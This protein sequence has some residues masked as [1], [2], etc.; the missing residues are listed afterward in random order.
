MC[1]RDRP[2]EN[3]ANKNFIQL[4]TRKFIKAPEKDAYLLNVSANGV[5]IEGDTYAGTFYG[6]QS[7][8]QL[9]P[10]AKSNFFKIPYVSIQDYPRFAYRGLMLDA[11]R[12]FFPV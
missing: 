3:E 12:H 7:L 9:L 10:T 8:I 1:I 5:A 2:I 11:C 6:I 4:T